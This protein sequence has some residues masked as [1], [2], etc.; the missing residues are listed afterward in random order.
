MTVKRKSKVQ[1]VCDR[2]E[3]AKISG[4]THSMEIFV[5]GSVL[6]IFVDGSALISMRMYRSVQPEKL[7]SLK[8]GNVEIVD[9]FNI[10][11]ACI[12]GE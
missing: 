2:M 12:T 8:N 5:D 11:A 6:E 3:R 9:A 4:E 1:G 10:R 7:F